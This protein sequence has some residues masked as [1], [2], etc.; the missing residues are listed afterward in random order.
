MDWKPCRLLPHVILQL[1][2]VERTKD[3]GWGLF[4]QFKISCNATSPVTRF[5]DVGIGGNGI[6]A[7][8]SQDD[9][10]V[11]YAYTGLSRVIKD[12]L[13]LATAGNVPPRAEHQF[14][15]FYNWHISP[16]SDLSATFRSFVPW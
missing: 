12:N 14:E 10:G 9:F 4:T 13:N 16:G 11:A 6:F 15:A 2:K 3:D 7:R 8:R 1:G 5:V